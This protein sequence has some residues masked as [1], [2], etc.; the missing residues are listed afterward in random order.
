ML[1]TR[2]LGLADYEEDRLEFIEEIKT[3]LTRMG[4]IIGLLKAFP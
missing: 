3:E 4:I 1:V 2:D